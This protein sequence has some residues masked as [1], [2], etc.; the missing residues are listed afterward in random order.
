MKPSIAWR[1][2]VAVGGCVG[3]PAL[4]EVR[5]PDSH[6]I[7]APGATVRMAEKGVSSPRKYPSRRKPLRAG[8]SRSGGAPH[9][10]IASGD[11]DTAIWV[12]LAQRNNGDAPYR[13][14]RTTRRDPSQ[15]HPAKMPSATPS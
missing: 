8:P 12:L 7:S 6:T 5:T 4:L 11:G 14:V 9:S 1:R 3:R 15:V 13:S 2:D 10:R